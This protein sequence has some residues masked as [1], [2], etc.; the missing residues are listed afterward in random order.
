MIH[1]QRTSLTS[2]LVAAALAFA[3]N[4]LAAQK[5]GIWDRSDYLDG[6]YVK[7][8]KHYQ[9]QCEAGEEKGDRLALHMEKMLYVYKQMFRGSS[10]QFKPRPV[11]LFKDLPSYHAYGGP[12]GS[13]GYYSRTSRELVLYDTTEWSDVE[14][15]SAPTTG[16]GA[17][18]KPR[19]PRLMKNNMDTLGVAAHEGW[20]QF[21]HWY[22]VSFVSLPSWINE[23]MG[24]Y[25]Y[26]GRPIRV[27][28]RVELDFSDINR[29]RFPIIYSAIKQG[30][31]EPIEKFLLMDQ[32][33]YYSNPSVCYAQGW[34]LC[35]FLNE[36][37]NRK[38][39][40]VIPNYIR[41]VRDDSNWENVTEKAFRGIDLEKLEKEFHEY[42]L[43]DMRARFEDADG[44]GKSDIEQAREAE[45]ARA[46]A[47]AEKA[48][49]E[50][51]KASE[52]EDGDGGVV[53]DNP[54]G[55]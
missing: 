19:R 8:T 3:P 29:D 26:S 7:E 23:G 22:V 37:D 32:R 54:V 14:E 55:G 21:F 45:E 10:S 51:R 31:H 25:F 13:A 12:Q 28:R 9:I 18:D 52:D 24:D 20:H 35:Y 36:S 42:V 39:N 15:V 34:A 47:A 50:A 38:Y 40:R 5:E 2:V 43:N 33:A 53:I 11:K 44:D 49:E 41:Y 1:L 16:E 6:W 17:N 27:G 48:L 30:R 4:G 46:R